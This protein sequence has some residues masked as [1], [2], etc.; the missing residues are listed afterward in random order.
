MVKVRTNRV[1]K[2]PQSPEN[3]TV[4]MVKPDAAYRA[5]ASVHRTG[6]PQE[7]NAPG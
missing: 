6:H 1:C 5:V 2:R 4:S 3:P 7:R